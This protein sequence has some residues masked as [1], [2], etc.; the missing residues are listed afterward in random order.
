MSVAKVVHT[1]VKIETRGLNGWKPHAR[2]ESIARDRPPGL[3]CEEEL[4]PAEAA[5]RDVLCNG[6]QP[7]FTHTKRTGLV[8]LRVRLNDHALARR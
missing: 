1:D 7:L 6:V 4:V 5:T 8:V 2:S 3:G